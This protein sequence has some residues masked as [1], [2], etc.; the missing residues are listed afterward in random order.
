[1][2]DLASL[3]RL[4]ESNLALRREF[5]GLG[6]DDVAVLRRLARWSDRIA[7]GLAHEFYDQQFAF[8]PT[9]AFF[10]SYAAA[11]G[12]SLDDLRRGLERAQAGYFRGIFAEAAAG[13][14]YGVAYFERRL[15]VGRLHNEIDLPFKWYIGSYVRYFDLVRKHL[16]R[17]YPHRPILRA[18]GERA[19]L[20][21]MNADM[22]AI[23]EAF[24]FDTFAAMGVD[25][26]AVPVPST[27]LDLSDCSGELKSMVRVP[28][29]GISRALATLRATSGQMAG[30]SEE[31]GRAVT[32][33]ARAA[34][35]VAA[36]AERQAR[37]VEQARASAGRTAEVASEASGASEEGFRAAAE[38]ADA[39]TTV[40]DAS[41]VVSSVM[42]SL[43]AKSDEIGGI[44][45]TISGIAGQTNLLALNAAIEAA[46]AGEQ[47]RGFSVVAEEVRKLAEQSQQAAEKI[48]GL[49]GEIQA[50]T[51]N[52][53]AAVGESASQIDAGAEIVA[54]ARESFAAISERVQDISARVDEI[55]A[56]TADVAAVAEESSA[57]AQEVSASSEQT[58]A[59][60]EEVAAAAGDLARTA[61]DLAA[62]VAGFRLETT[63]AAAG[64]R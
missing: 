55:V 29:Q 8:A 43:E 3:Y 26:A 20:A 39:M 4:N 32:E 2:A 1:M 11:A 60:T 47:G 13:G 64:A 33:I 25:L 5:M 23:V 56:A 16:R 6:K 21:V 14:V 10:R 54:R 30:S 57:A 31:A 44:V 48:A 46:R 19:I 50:E 24:Y 53:V 28:L 41:A 15:Q 49:I 59:S 17:S 63:D 7:D 37:M 27:D 9:V 18:R 58:S 36:G 42:A 40:R 61:E 52:A 35:D 62:I 45:E 38:A 22:Q 51:G 12:R 34:G